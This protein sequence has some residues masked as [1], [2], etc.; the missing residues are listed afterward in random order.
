RV[1]EIQPTALVDL[2]RPAYKLG[3][4]EIDVKWQAH[5]LKVSVLPERSVYKVRERARVKIV[6]LRSDGSKPPPGSEAAIAAVD[7]G[8]LELMPNKS[9]DLLAAMMGRRSYSVATS[10]AQMQVIGRRHFGLKAVAQGGGGGKMI[11]RELF[12]TL[13]YWNARVPLDASGEAVVEIPLN[14]SL[15]AFRI[16]AV[17][18]G[19]AGLFGSG[20]ATLRSSQDLMLFA[21]IAPVAREG[22]R[23]KS[24]FTLRNASDRP[25]QIHAMARIAGLDNA[26]RTA[27]V[28]LGAGEAR[29][30]GWDIQV[31]IG[32]DRLVYEIEAS[33]SGGG[34][35][36]LRI[37]QKISAAVPTRTYQATIRQVDKNFVLGVERPKDALPG[38]GG[39][40]VSFRPKLA[41]SLAGV[42]EFMRWYPYT[43]MEQLTSRAV[44]LRDEKMWRANMDA[45]PSY[46]DSAGLVKFFP[47][48]TEGSEVLTSY[49]LAIA[50]EAGW[51]IP[52]ATRARM[53]T[54]LR[55]FVE[56][57]LLRRSALPTADL[58][59]RKMAAIDALA[60]WDAADAS[61]LSSIAVDANL[62]P[63]SGVID[64][65]NV[66]RRLPEVPNREQKIQQAEQI[67]RARLNFQGTAMNFSTEKT[68]GLWWLMV[69]GDVN[70]VRL[71]LALLP[72]EPWQADMARL[73]QGAL[74]RQR[75]GAWGSTVANAWG[76]LAFEK[77][78]RTFEST[79]V[80]GESAARLSGRSQ[81]VAWSEA[82][83]APLYRLPG[84]LNARM[85]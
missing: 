37:A 85:S 2:G 60:R 44:A 79:P 47:D 19:D 18:S 78:S 36:R 15:T 52:A 21:G 32:A 22:D 72:S 1:N 26:P 71:I 77:F 53:E 59:L 69:N 25:M 65:L 64:W 24:E 84:R 75:R 27:A 63:T 42:A 57:K 81:K 62:W 67:L 39:I 73:A 3:I 29:E 6:A 55:Q 41:E 50:Q 51:D 45:L 8:L 16:A 54:A 5:E 43:C 56:G 23:L 74:L 68:D 49:L 7:E 35:D 76:V 31:P 66:L 34:V 13:L 12:D 28:K 17:V 33:E 9:W 46:L 11:T 10:T 30:I 83:R 80:A 4:A 38:R 82:R 70:A 40:N 58:A 48:M 14:D 20:S 61:L